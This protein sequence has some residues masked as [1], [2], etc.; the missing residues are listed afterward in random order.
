MAWFM[1]LALAR[2]LERAEGAVSTSFVEVRRQHAADTGAAWHDFDGTY[3]IF[4]GVDSPLTQTFGLGVRGPTTPEALTAIEDFFEARGAAVMHEVSTLAGVEALATLVDRG[5]RPVEL[6]TVL[7]QGI[8]ERLDAPASA[9]GLRVRTMEAADRAAWVEAS[10]AGWSEDPA[11]VPLIRSIAEASSANR[12][13]VRFVAERDGAVVATASMGIHDGVALLAGASTIPSAR[14]LGAQ[15]M[16]LAARLAE[17]QR[18]S[19]DLAM[20]VSAPG[21]TSQRNAERRGFRVAYTRSKWRLLRDDS[22]TD[23]ISL[24]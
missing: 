4:D 6:S 1:D 18:R 2:R 20:M 15:S 16:L 3:A 23:R 14:G 10:V 24:P 22:R 11:V 5:Y 9:S 7:V 13:M 12:A 8:A 19:C 21:S 17:A